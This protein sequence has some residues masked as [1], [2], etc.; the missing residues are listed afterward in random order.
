MHKFKKKEAFSYMLE[1]LFRI[2]LFVAI[3]VGVVMLALTIYDA[4]TPATTATMLADL[5]TTPTGTINTH[6]IN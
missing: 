2:V 4:V 1:L 5:T 6:L 3:A